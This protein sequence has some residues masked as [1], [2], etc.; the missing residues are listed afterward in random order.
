M[1]K[2][3]F[4]NL[5]LVALAALL[6]AASFPNP[7]IENG[8][9]LLAWVA[10]VPI[11]ALLYRVSLGASVLWGALYGYS[12]YLLFNYWLAAFHPLAGIIVHGV[13]MAYMAGLFFALRL[14]IT[15]FPRRAYLAHWAIW[16][17]YEYL[18]TLGFLGYPYGI[19]GYTQWRMIPL[20]QI[21]DIFG[22]WGVSALVVFPSAWLGA[23]L[24]RGQGAPLPKKARA[25]RSEP[26]A[27][28]REAALRVAAFFR[29]ERASALG[30]L[31]A[32]AAALV[33]GLAVP[34][35]FS[36]AP[37]ANIALIQQNE[38]PWIGGVAEFRRNFEVLTRL[39]DEALAAY[40][41]PDMVVWSEVAFPP[42]VVFHYTYRQI[43]ASFWLVSDLLDYL[44]RQD[45]PFVIGNDD[46]RW[47]DDGEP[48]NF[49]A[50]LFFE[51]RE[52]AE[53]YRK[54][55][56]VPFTEHFP[57][58]RQFPGIYRALREADT[59]FW[60]YGTEPTV[61]SG[62]G[63]YFS[64]TICFEDSYGYLSRMFVRAGAE[65]LVNLSN[66]AWSGSLT[67]QNQQ[68]SM[69]VFRAV[70]TRRAVVRSTASGQTAG[71]APDGRIIAMAPPFE[72]AWLTV[73]VPIVRDRTTLYTRF[74][75]FL[76][77]A[78]ALASALLLIIG[79]AMC[80][81]RKRQAK[82]GADTRR[83]KK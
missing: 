22:V 57:F 38:D 53:V 60:K 2:P 10:Y 69:S 27:F 14:A 12:A 48:L 79:G 28:F 64:T 80:I 11:F 6:F 4:A 3:F 5:G 74:G 9:P 76:G 70:E 1:I 67:S 65:V 16:L 71:I 46:Q 19:T 37:T 49:N 21:A 81:M 40:P 68:L 23:A 82:A 63:F 56:L 77:V 83:R 75:D 41:R 7:V 32:L 58:H 17:A 44:E 47:G 29:K 66:K 31:C 62:P 25:R 8:V 59:H 18:R 78:F 51:G 55:H 73:S 42:R 35:D 30:W 26:P 13:Y 33:Y 36:G 45:V 15:F 20:I 50:A 39:S 52:I 61:F 24:G 54:M 43:P 34:A 72:E